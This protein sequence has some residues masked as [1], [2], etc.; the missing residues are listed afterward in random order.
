MA[1]T[2]KG[3]FPFKTLNGQLPAMKNFA[4]V[5]T[6]YYEGQVLRAS[7]TTPSAKAL[8][9][10]GTTPLGVIGCNVTNANATGTNTYPVYLADGNT[11]FEARMG[12]GIDCTDHILTLKPITVSSGDHTVCSTTGATAANNVLQI[13]DVHPRETVTGTPSNKRVLVKFARSL[14]GGPTKTERT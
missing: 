14:V 6:A 10:R 12:N 3:F 9:T 11:I 13:Y 5:Q 8:G 2:K 4:L 7:A 1:L